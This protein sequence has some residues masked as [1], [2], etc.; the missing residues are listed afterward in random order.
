MLERLEVFPSGA[1]GRVPHLSHFFLMLFVAEPEE[2][3]V[4]LLGN[5]VAF[6]LLELRDLCKDGFLLLLAFFDFS[7]YFR[8][9]V[10]VY[11]QRAFD[12]KI[13]LIVLLLQVQF[14]FELARI[15]TVFLS[16]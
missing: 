7:L 13:L 12:L 3:Q 6:G 2:L 1:N 5:D 4:L 10:I 16:N 14:L 8:D 11:F 15:L 9:L